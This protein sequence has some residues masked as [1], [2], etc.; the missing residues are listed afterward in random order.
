MT[1]VY[2]QNHFQTRFEWGEQGL[3]ALA[4]SAATIVIV[5][6]LSF[7]TAVDI[8][9]SRGASVY[10][11]RWKDER[12]AQMAT[13]L[14]AKLAVPRQRVS[15]E[16][17][18]SLSPPTLRSLPPGSRLVLPSPNGATLSTIAAESGATVIAGCLRNAT[19]VGRFCRN[20][21][22]EVAVIAAGERWGRSE[23]SL[24]PAVEDLIGAGAILDALGSESVSPEAQA[25][26]AAFR[27]CR[28]S[29]R[30]TLLDASSGRELIEAGYPLDVEVAA[31]ID[32][33]TAVPC[34]HGG[35]FINDNPGERGLSMP[36]P[37]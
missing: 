15:P 26:I 11:A 36:E 10:P 18:Y 9:V 3:H 19:T 12:S 22:G 1:N 29:V 27:S 28:E 13:S 20:Q 23:G 33:S 35:C 21:A 7:S 5:D 16:Q 32:T 30:E 4:P 6:V 25:A 34:L 37:G 8:A 24:R 31:E 17:P 2:S 14:G